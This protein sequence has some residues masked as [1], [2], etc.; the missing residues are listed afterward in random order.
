MAYLVVSDHALSTVLLVE[1][2]GQLF[3]V[4]YVSHVLVEVEQCHPFIEKFAYAL[5]IV[6]QKMHPYFQSPGIVILTDQPL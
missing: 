4:Y 1:R 3:P 2:D 5:L 6:S